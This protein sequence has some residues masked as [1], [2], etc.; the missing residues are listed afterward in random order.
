MSQGN[1]QRLCVHACVGPCTRVHIRM[2]AQGSC[3]FIALLYFLLSSQ[4]HSLLPSLP[5][6]LSSKLFNGFASSDSLCLLI[7]I[8]LILAM[9]IYR[10]SE[11][12]I[13]KMQKY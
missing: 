1:V 13:W 7:L 4:L 5:P 12:G 3:Y 9:E 11:D 2:Y 8:Y 6:S 10:L